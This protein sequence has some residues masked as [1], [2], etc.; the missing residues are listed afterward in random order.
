MTGVNTINRNMERNKEVRKKYWK[1]MDFYG[2]STTVDAFDR[3]EVGRVADV[4]MEWQ[5]NCCRYE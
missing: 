3:N 1:K 4:V 2:N 5:M